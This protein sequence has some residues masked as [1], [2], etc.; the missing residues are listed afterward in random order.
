M[1]TATRAY[2]RGRLAGLRSVYNHRA[3]TILNSGLGSRSFR[4]LD[5]D[6][7]CWNLPGHRSAFA[8]APRLRVKHCPPNPQKSHALRTWKTSVPPSHIM[9]TIICEGG[10]LVFPGTPALC[11]FRNNHDGAI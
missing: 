6:Y 9:V 10:T 5:N 2:A 8:L 4:L 3:F 7:V 11:W 1:G